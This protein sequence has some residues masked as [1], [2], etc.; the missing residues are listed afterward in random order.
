MTAA[1]PTL[2][3]LGTGAAYANAP[4]TTTMLAVSDG[5]SVIVID[6]GGDVIHRMLAAGLD[7]QAIRMLLLTHGHIDHIG[8][9]PL[10]MRKLSLGQRCEPLPICGPEVTLAHVRS[11][12]GLYDTTRWKHDFARTWH[13][14]PLES[15]QLVY[16]DGTWQI[17]ASPTLHSA[18]GIS[19]RITHI[20]SRSSVAYSSDTGPTSQLVELAACADIL[21]H[22]ATGPF[23]GHATALQAATAAKNADV[24]RLVLVHR[25][26]PLPPGELSEARCVFPSTEEGEELAQY[27][28]RPPLD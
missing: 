15:R 27:T 22:E 8:G 1:T 5:M 11:L 12:L 7:P 25:I 26:D 16:L 20:P 3:L 2:H 23:P 24:Q 19:I 21:V 28:L 14:V 10:M 4:L 17:R 18:P 13:P 9:F 6:C